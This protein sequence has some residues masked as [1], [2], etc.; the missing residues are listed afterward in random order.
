MDV[1]HF[2]GSW[3]LAEIAGEIVD[4]GA[5]REIR[6]DAGR[7]IGQVGVN[8]FS[9]SYTQTEDGIEF[10]P[11]AMTRMAGPP[12]LM[13]L[14]ARFHQALL[15]AETARTETRLL[16]GDMVLVLQTDQGDEEE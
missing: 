6:F 1:D 11:A 4:A 14:E 2:E 7:V 10:G 5:P 16:L 15:A 13:D 8:R 9:G 12:E 3:L